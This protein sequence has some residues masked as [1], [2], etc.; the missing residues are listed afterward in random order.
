[1]TRHDHSFLASLS[2][3]RP[4][5]PCAC[6]GVLRRDHGARRRRRAKKWD[7][8][9]RASEIKRELGCSEDEEE[10]EEG[11]KRWPKSFW[12]VC[13]SLELD[14]FATT[15]GACAA[16]GFGWRRFVRLAYDFDRKKYQ[17]WASRSNKADRSDYTYAGAG[18]ARPSARG[19]ERL[20][21]VRHKSRRGRDPASVDIR[22]HGGNGTHAKHRRG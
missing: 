1:M 4:D 14:R 15:M 3:P 16:H 17:E 21:L 19:H 13:I 12:R 7:G 20:P 18:S 2:K 11:K 9:A 8:A 10:D 22:Y 6:C 5:E